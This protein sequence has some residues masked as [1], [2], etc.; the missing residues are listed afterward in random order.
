MG[1]QSLRELSDHWQLKTPVASCFI[2]RC[3]KQIWCAFTI[4]DLYTHPQQPED[5]WWFRVESLAT[6]ICEVCQKYWTSRAYL[7]VDECMILYLEH[8]WHAIKTSHKSIK[9]DYKIWA[10]EDLDYIFN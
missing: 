4:Q 2:K 6:T 3:F 7:A 9:Q 5:S 10:L 1:I 8:I